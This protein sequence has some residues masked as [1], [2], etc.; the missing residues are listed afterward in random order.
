MSQQPQWLCQMT[1]EPVTAK[2]C[3]RCAEQ[4]NRPGCPFTPA[5]LRA[6]AKANEPDPVL[7][8]LQRIGY[9]VIRVSSLVGCPRKAWYE[10]TVGRPLE[11]PMEHWARLRGS[12]FHSA[13]EDMGNGLVEKRFTTFLY[14]PPVFVS[15]RVDG[16]DPETG[17]LYDYK[18]V[19]AK[20]RWDRT[21]KKYVTFTLKEPRSHHTAQLR[22]YAWLLWKNGYD[23]PSRMRLV[24]IT[25][26]HVTSFD[27][28]PPTMEEMQDIE[29][30]VTEKARIIVADDAPPAEPDEDWECRYCPFT[31]C[32]KH[33]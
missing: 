26:A 13:F 29:S 5:I 6:L 1:G 24:Y 12:I 23:I 11:R 28:V 10:R 20:A 21:L 22:L 30:E 18:T 17:T 16:Y 31:Q 4:G 9:P 3:L 32:P 33:P 15:G 19:N 25:M 2:D 27:L 7:E 8:N 14:D